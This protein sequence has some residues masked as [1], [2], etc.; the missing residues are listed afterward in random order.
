MGHPCAGASLAA[1][2]RVRAFVGVKA[3]AIDRGLPVSWVGRAFFY[4]PR[5]H[6]AATPPLQPQQTHLSV[7]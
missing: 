5:L 1:T 4:R 6:P 7:S 2:G 3:L